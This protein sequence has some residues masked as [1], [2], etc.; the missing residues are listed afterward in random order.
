MKPDQTTMQCV[1]GPLENKWLLEAEGYRVYTASIDGL[2][3]VDFL[4][5][6]SL[7]D[8]EAIKAIIR[9]GLL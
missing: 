4:V 3:Y 8:E 9:K 2:I 1:G 5:H 7:S 6:S